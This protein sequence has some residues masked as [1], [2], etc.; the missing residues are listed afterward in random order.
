MTPFMNKDFLLQTLTARELYAS[1]EGLPIIDYHCHLSPEEIA[2]DKRFSSI[3]EVWLGGDHYKWRAMRSAGIPENLVTGDAPD[4][5]RFLAWSRILPQ[6]IGNPLYH[7]TH[8]ELKR[9]FDYDGILSPKTAEAV[10]EHCN[11]QLERPEFSVSGILKRFNVE[12]L[13]TTDDPADS[14]EHHIRI[15]Q[16]GKISTVV[17][18]TLRPGGAMSIDTDAYAAYI[19]RLAEAADMTISGYADLISALY[20]RCDFFHSIGGRLADHA[21]DPAVFEPCTE[22]QADAIVKAALA[23]KAPSA[24]ELNQYRTRLNVDLARKYSQLGWVMQL[25]IGA[26]RNTNK[27]MFARIGADTGYDCM[28]DQALAVP[29]TRLL[30]EMNGADNL[31]P[32]TILYSLNPKDNYTLGTIIGC[33]QDGQTAGK[34][35]LGSGWW[36]NDQ[37]FGME[38]Q[39]IALANLGLLPRFVGMLTDSRSFLSYPRHEYFRRILCNLVGQWVEDGEYPADMETLESIVG[40]I[41]YGNARDY[42]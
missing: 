9:C 15:K 28:D 3:T 4:K 11:A 16:E 41:S 23:G 6:L 12:K 8:L 40:G 1:C 36:F 17:L 19:Q 22:T 29:L 32:K 38:Q 24:L 27:A 42:F 18:P 7:W 34:L 39:M 10:W 35:Q 13:C 25:H 14:L 2:Q 31:L 26:V 5:E 20:K 21:L 37:K 30:N 33:F